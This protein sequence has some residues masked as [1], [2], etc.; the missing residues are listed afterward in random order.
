MEVLGD[1]FLLQY[2]SVLH[3]GG[4]LCGVWD[5]RARTDVFHGNEPDSAVFGLHWLGHLP[6]RHGLFLVGVHL[7][8][9]N[10]LK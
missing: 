8:V 1:Q 10:R 5:N 7:Q 9:E 3:H 2:V 6:D 4:G